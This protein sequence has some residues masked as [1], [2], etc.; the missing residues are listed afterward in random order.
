VKSIFLPVKQNTMRKNLY[1]TIASFLLVVLFSS[2]QKSDVITSPQS[3]DGTWIVTGITSDRAYDFN[4]DGRSETDIY[5]S[6][7]SCQR[8]IAVTFDQNGYGQ[9]RQGCNAYWQ[10]ITWQLSN[11]NRQLDILLPNDQINLAITAFDNY[12]IRGTD[13]VTIGGNNYNITYTFQR[14]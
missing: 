9:M 1:F 3:L 4:G 6:Y 7:N 12:T 8:D 13:P 2:C 11:N 14:R 5:G 10:N